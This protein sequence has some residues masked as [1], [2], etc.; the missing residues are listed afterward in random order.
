[1]TER[2]RTPGEP[3]VPQPSEEPPATTRGRAEGWVA[4]QGE[5]DTTPALGTAG[6]P[7]RFRRG[8]DGAR[9]ALARRGWGDAR[10]SY[11]YK[12]DTQYADERPAPGELSEAARRMRTGPAPDDVHGPI[13]K[14]PVWSW[15]I[16]LYFWFGGIASGSAFAAA[17]CDLAG[18]HRAATVARRV[19]MA[20][21]AP[22][23]AL[24]VADLGRPLRFIY[25]LRILKP[26][27]PMS[28]GSWC[29]AAF[30]GLGAG[31]A[32]ADLFERPRAARVLGGAM[33]VAGTYLGSY[34]GVLLV[35]T[36]VPLWNRSRLFLGP[37][38]VATATATGASATRLALVAT[39]MPAGHPTRRAL[40]RVEMAA[41]LAE[42]A[43]AELNERRLGQ[44][45][46]PL[47]SGRPGRLF[48]GAKLAV[49]S[50]LGLHLL[51]RRLGPRA[52]HAASG[53]YLAGG[54][55]LR[56][57]WV[58]AGKASAADTLAVA[59]AARAAHGRTS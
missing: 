5:R 26:R 46:E 47:H 24:L 13:T 17:A 31:A 18:D 28:T 54:L 44:L 50:G 15:E 56:F 58:T 53:L 34:T 38:F 59:G 33:A 20:A 3:P 10:W 35:A 27:S 52:H 55:A 37:M 25:M 48:R 36:A 19:S 2:L 6:E 45:V 7:G 16:P 49:I 12:A 57:A 41:M 11:L 9:V 43:L 32:A 23:P 8:L 40:G 4:P 30:G 14:P 1:M 42:L 21:L 22:C 29:L 51:R 39:G